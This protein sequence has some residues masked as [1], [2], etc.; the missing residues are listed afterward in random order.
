M[1]E[2]V[3]LTVF[4]IHLIFHHWIPIKI[5]G[6]FQQNIFEHDVHSIGVTGNEHLNKGTVNL[7]RSIIHFNIDLGQAQEISCGI[8]CFV[9]QYVTRE[10]VFLSG[11]GLSENINARAVGVQ[12]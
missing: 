9:T 4:H 6:I 5:I 3:C 11:F 2:R 7:S 8:F 10:Y 12:F 1:H